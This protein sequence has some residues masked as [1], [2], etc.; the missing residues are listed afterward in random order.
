MFT[1]IEFLR[2]F[3]QIIFRLTSTIIVVNTFVNQKDKVA[4]FYAKEKLGQHINDTC[5]V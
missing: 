1:N 5:T 4:L 2:N 3:A